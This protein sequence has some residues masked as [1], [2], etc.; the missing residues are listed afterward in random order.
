ML[1]KQVITPN[2]YHIKSR[3]LLGKTINTEVFKQENGSF[4]AFSHYVKY[5]DEDI[6][7]IEMHHNEETAIRQSWKAL[8][9]ELK[10]VV[11]QNPKLLLLDTQNQ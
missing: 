1:D 7:G 3:D 4:N 10:K 5:A 6:V 8:R 2:F 9:K 11:E